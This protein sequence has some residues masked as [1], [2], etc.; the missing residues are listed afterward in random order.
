MIIGTD[1]H[2]KQGCLIASDVDV[3]SDPKSLRARMN[4]V[5]ERTEIY[6]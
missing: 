1:T 3:G 5:P 4:N 2:T 6:Y